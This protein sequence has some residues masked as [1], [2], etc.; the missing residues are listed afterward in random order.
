M[1]EIAGA[2]PLEQAF[3]NLTELLNRGGESLSE[4]DRQLLLSRNDEPGDQIAVQRLG[5][6]YEAIW[7]GFFRCAV[8]GHA[9]L[10]VEAIRQRFGRTLQDN[11]PGASG[12]FLRFATTYWT[13][14]L[15]VGELFPAH[16]DKTISQLLL[17]LD[18]DIGSVFFPTL[19][20]G[21]IPVEKREK[22]QRQL[23]IDSG[24]PIDVEDFI[25]GNPILRHKTSSG[26]FGAIAAAGLLVALALCLLAL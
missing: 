21:T 16:V 25:H 15:V 4:A 20:P 14:K 23:I 24:A 22:A 1:A 7:K 2:A 9:F 10:P 19:K 13:Y 8:E 6:L 17:K 11:Y 18:F 5:Q 26:C 12:T 3:R